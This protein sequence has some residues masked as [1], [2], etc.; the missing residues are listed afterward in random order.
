M[1]ILPE[2]E[3]I[4]RGVNVEDAAA[5][6]HYHDVGLDQRNGGLAA[7]PRGVDQGVDLGRRQ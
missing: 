7:A 1:E 2:R 3:S 4:L 6:H 5:F